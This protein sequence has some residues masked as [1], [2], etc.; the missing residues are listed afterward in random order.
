MLA[1]LQWPDRDI[2]LIILAVAASLG[3]VWFSAR[4]IDRLDRQVAELRQRI[5]S[6]TAK[7]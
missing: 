4:R 5:D 7:R 2:V 6:L 1:T 3:S